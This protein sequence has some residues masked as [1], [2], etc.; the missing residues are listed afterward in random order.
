M[1]DEIRIRL[2]LGL[3]AI[4]IVHAALLGIVFTALHQSPSKQN[5][6]LE[7]CSA[8]HNCPCN[9]PPQRP[10]GQIE[11]LPEPP[12][13]NYEAQREIK[14]QQIRCWPRRTIAQ[15]ALQNG[16]TVTYTTVSNP[17][18][19]VSPV[20]VPTQPTLAA[21]SVAQPV[22]KPA[23]V[24][25]AV[26]KS[27][28]TA[29]SALE[30]ESTESKTPIAA[31][32]S[33]PPKKS[34]QIALFVRDDSQSQRLQ[35]WFDEHPMLQDLRESS[36]YQIYTA[37]NA[38]YR[39][40]YVNIVPVEQFPVVLFQDATG[41]H[42]H[43]A[44]R[45]MIPS[46]PDELYSDLK[47]GYELYQQAKRAEKTGAV[48]SEG[49]SW[50]DAISPTLYLAAEDCPDGYCPVTPTDSWRP[51]D[52]TR[53]GLFDRNNNRNSRSALFWL[54]AGEMATIALIGIA[55]ILIVFIVFKRGIN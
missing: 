13:V 31:P 8:D 26:G 36:E 51:V 9:Q 21:P 3:I 14:Q 12:R 2:S 30:C 55:A 33:P 32:A 40:R 48:K 19:V 20:T 6:E 22:I 43:A 1:K 18:A 49:Y 4:A 25:P 27:P 50:D 17:K 46:T 7:H 11:T 10:V 53:D 5:C 47:Q 16:Y 44:G 15:P 42:I 37:E 41:G 39:T 34:F 38:I 45:T 28:E 29:L 52:R 54:S 35:A 24:Q 23:V